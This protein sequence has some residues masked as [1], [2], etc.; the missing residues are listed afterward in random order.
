MKFLKKEP[1]DFTYNVTSADGRFHP[2]SIRMVLNNIKKQPNC[3]KLTGNF[4]KVDG[5][6]TQDEKDSF[7][8]IVTSVKIR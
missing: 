1:G 6:T 8:K 4:R 7:A 3:L 2:A 5:S